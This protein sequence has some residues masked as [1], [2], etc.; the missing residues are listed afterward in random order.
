M[1]AEFALALT[2]SVAPPQGSTGLRGSDVVQLVRD[3]CLDTGLDRAAFERLGRERRWRPARLNNRSG[4]PGWS[5]AFRANGA[6]VMMMGGQEPGGPGRGSA[7]VCS[8][9]VEQAG[10]GLEADF[11]TLADS[12]GLEGENVPVDSPPGFVPPRMWSSLGGHTL[13]YAAAADGRAVIS[14]SRQIVISEPA[15]ASPPGN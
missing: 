7:L 13:T 12:L 6:L 4:E 8:V 9:S 14:F 1:F 15:P 11:A 5:T 10:H 2:L 3:V